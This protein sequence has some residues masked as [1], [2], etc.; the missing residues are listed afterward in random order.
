MSTLCHIFCLL[1]K[2]LSSGPLSPSL[3]Q[4]RLDPLDSELFPLNQ[5]K[6]PEYFFNSPWQL[7]GIASE[8]KTPLLSWV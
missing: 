5:D 3:A 1:C 4:G 7:P 6:V 2:N 8:N